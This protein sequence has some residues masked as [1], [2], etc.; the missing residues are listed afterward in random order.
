MLRCNLLINAL[1]EGGGESSMANADALN[2]AQASVSLICGPV[3]EVKLEPDI[4]RY[5]ES[6]RNK[7]YQWSRL[8][9]FRSLLNQENIR[10]GM[11]ELHRRVDTCIYA[12]HVRHLSLNFVA[13]PI[14]S[15]LC[16]SG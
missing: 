11:D 1:S 12:C 10:E 15:H 8:N 9:T 14:I 13:V 4:H 7:V 16:L 3:A 2:E 5:L 6:V